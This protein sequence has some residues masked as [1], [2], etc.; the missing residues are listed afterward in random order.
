LLHRVVAADFNFEE[1]VIDTHHTELHV[2]RSLLRG[3]VGRLRWTEQ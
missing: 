1:A 3:E 2:L